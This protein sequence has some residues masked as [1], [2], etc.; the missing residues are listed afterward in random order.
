MLK[1]F[2][3]LTIFIGSFSWQG[4]AYSHEAKR[5]D[6]SKQI[7]LPASPP[8][9]QQQTGSPVQQEAQKQRPYDVRIISVTPRDGYDKA[10]FYANMILALVGIGGIVIAVFTLMSIDTQA[11]DIKTQAKEMQRQNKNMIRAERA[12]IVISVRETNPGEFVFVAKNEG[13]TPARIQS[14]WCANIWSPRGSTFKVPP[15]H[16]TDES[17]M[18]NP[19]FLLPPNGEKTVWRCTRQAVEAMSGGGPGEQSLFSRGFGTAS[20]YGRIRY[21]NV[22]DVNSI[23]PHETRWLYLLIPQP[24][25]VPIPDPFHNEH[26]SYT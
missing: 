22:M 21:L 12:W 2:L 1:N 17:Q 20:F 24:G 23:T 7:A 16:Q 6:K 26:N 15:D 11:K 14:V 3:V 9:S 10:V 5:S 18:Q 8:A 4:Y 13:K 19:P 25:T